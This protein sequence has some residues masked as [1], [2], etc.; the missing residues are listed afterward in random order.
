MAIKITPTWLV[1][2]S[3]TETFIYDITAHQEKHAHAETFKPAMTL[4]HPEGRLKISELVEDRSGK[5]GTNGV[6]GKYEKHDDPHEVE[7]SKFAKEIAA[8]LEKG[9]EENQYEQLI[10]CASPR[11]HGVLNEHLSKGVAHLVMKHI[12]KDYAA[13]EHKELNAAIKKIVDELV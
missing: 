7:L 5:P 12:Q 8:V 4:S 10:L 3:V 13:L 9:R 1:I 2:A 6:H 11:F